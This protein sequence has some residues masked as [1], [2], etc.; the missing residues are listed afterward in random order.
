MSLLGVDVGTTGCKAAAFDLEGRMLAS[1]YR[2]FAI[3]SPQPG[4]A[5]VDV[6]EVWRLIQ[7]CIREAVRGTKGDPAT[8][9]SVSSLGEAVVPVSRDRRILGPSILN[10]DTRGAEYV[11]PLRASVPD[12]ELYALNGN[13]HGNH[14]G[15]T[16]LM[17]LRDHRP[18]L[19][20][21][22]DY[23]YIGADS[24]PS[25]S[26]P[27]RRSI[28]PQRTAPSASILEQVAWSH[29]MLQAAGL[30]VAKL[31]GPV[32]TGTIVGRVSAEASA[33]LGLPQGAEIV[34]GAHDQCANAVGCGVIGEGA[35]MYGMGTFTCIVPVFPSRPEPAKMMSHG[36]NTEH[37]AVPGSFVTFIYNQ[38]GSLLKWYRD[39][40][41]VQERAA[42]K[43]SADTFPLLAGGRSVSGANT[44]RGSD[45]TPRLTAS[46]DLYDLLLAEMPPGPSGVIVLPHFT[47][48][49][50]PEFIADSC[51]MIAGLH[52]DTS[53]G[54]ILKGVLEGT[55]FYLREIVDALPEGGLDIAEYT[56]V[57][58]GAKSMAWVQLAADIFGRPFRVPEVTEAGTLG[59]ALMA[60]VGTGAYASYPEAVAAAVRIAQTVDPDLAEHDRYEPLFNQYCK[61]APLLRGYLQELAALPLPAGGGIA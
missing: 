5:E 33:E 58:G 29:R 54:R 60:G 53:R 32:P 26:A 34:A 16:K 12:A 14:Y 22:T 2:E 13:T 1:A 15:V 30:H 8:A 52:L 42:A 17:W 27:S 21:K 48:T 39:T 24:S 19:Y 10:F 49:G 55:T 18:D 3:R 51:G 43:S 41:A 40:F 57:G 4:C 25:C 59:A 36:L 31:P 9:L 47:T 44:D 61:T 37:H 7:D 11:E 38:G 45:E 20:A 23:S 56:A 28:S 50:P 35:A 46:S 6:A